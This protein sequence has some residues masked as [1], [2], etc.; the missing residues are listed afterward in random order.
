VKRRHRIDRPYRP[1]ATTIWR[2]KSALRAV[3]VIHHSPALTALRPVNPEDKRI[4][5]C[6]SAIHDSNKDFFSIPST[7]AAIISHIPHR[8]ENQIS[9]RLPAP[10]PTAPIR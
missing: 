4:F 3:L 5:F 1:F 8:S 9:A 10:P 6:M 2:S 7:V